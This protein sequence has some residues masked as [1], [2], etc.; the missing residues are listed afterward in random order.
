MQALRPPQPEPKFLTRCFSHTR[1][2]ALDVADHSAKKR[3]LTP[4]RPLHPR[5]PSSIAARKQ[6]RR[7]KSGLSSTCSRRASNSPA[8]PPPPHLAARASTRVN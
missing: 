2:L 1:Q 8:P 6:F 4:Q 7:G 3:L 5:P